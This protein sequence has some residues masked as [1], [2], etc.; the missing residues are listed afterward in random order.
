MFKCKVHGTAYCT[1]YVTNISV[2]GQHTKK[3]Y[4]ACVLSYGSRLDSLL[5]HR[6]SIRA[7]VHLERRMSVESLPITEYFIPRL[8][9]TSFNLKE[10]I[11]YHTFIHTYLSH[12]LMFVKQT[13]NCF[14]QRYVHNMLISCISLAT[15]DFLGFDIV[16]RS[17]L[18]GS[19]NY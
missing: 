12:N 2:Y 14:Q 13:L 7:G 3:P 17:T 6:H 8:H 5:P 15:P 10:D 4:Q 11:K 9:M 1:V 16:P 19:Y 18:T